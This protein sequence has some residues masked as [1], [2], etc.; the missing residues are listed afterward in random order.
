MRRKEAGG[1]HLLSFPGARGKRAALSRWCRA[2][3]ILA[4]RVRAGLLHTCRWV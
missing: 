4:P 2:Q 3:G 1:C